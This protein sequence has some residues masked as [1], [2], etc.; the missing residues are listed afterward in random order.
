MIA[1]TR[2]TAPALPTALARVFS[3]PGKTTPISRAFGA[4][5]HGIP[6][7]R[8]LSWAFVLLLWIA[9]GASA[10]PQIPPVAPAETPQEPAQP[11]LAGPPKPELERPTQWGEPTEV[12]VLIYVIDVDEIDSAEQS[13][14]ASVF[15]AARWKNPLLVHPGPGP[16]HRS[17]IDV[18]TPRLTIVNQQQSWPAFP[19]AVEVQPDGTVFL[20]QKIWGRFSQPLDLRHFPL[21][22]QTLRIHLVAT[23]LL[24]QDVK[25]IPM[26]GTHGRQSGIASVFS[27]PDFEVV[28]WKAEPKPYLPFQ[29]EVGAAGFEMKIEVRR[30]VVYWVAKIIVPLCLI[31]I[32][33]WLPCWIDPKEIGTN[34]GV[35]TTAFLTLVAYLF[36]ITVL[37]PRV[38]YI[39]RIDRFV[40]LSMLM[41]FV[42]LLQTV[43]N[44]AL[45][46]MG[47]AQSAERIDRWSRFVYPVFLAGILMVSFVW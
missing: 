5:N 46:K 19:W 28:S 35:S 33:S 9:A 39:T 24:E 4:P 22:R 23:G 1:N 12:E 7:R 14:T 15:Y 38:S 30:G 34:I 11:A 47:K 36:A 37:L 20:R 45:V 6:G 8:A 13:F 16:L 2:R 17:M 29:G 10:Q 21:D 43:A 42:G 27:L 40:F 41:V 25:M 32:M 31:V 26:A 3:C 18:W 44:T